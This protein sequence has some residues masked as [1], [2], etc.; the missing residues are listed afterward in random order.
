MCAKEAAG[1]TKTFHECG[2]ARGEW[3]QVILALRH[4]RDLT[5]TSTT[6]GACDFNEQ[7]LNSP[8][9]LVFLVISFV[10]AKLLESLVINATVD[11]QQ[12]SSKEMTHNLFF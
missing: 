7:A 5:I 9:F 4:K 6:K 8:I 2:A 3:T 1:H 12:T 10:E 11:A